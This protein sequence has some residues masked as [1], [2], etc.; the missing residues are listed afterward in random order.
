MRESAAMGFTED[1]LPLIV[2]IFQIIQSIILWPF[3]KSKK[4]L[5]GEVVC[6]TGAGSGIGALMAKKL[7]D[8][9]C[10]IV[11]WDVNVK[12]NEATVEEIRKNGGE[13]YGFKCDV[14]NREEVYEVAKKSAKLAGDVTMLINNAG[15]VGGK[16]FLEADDAMVQKTFEVNSISHFWTTKAFLPKMVENNHGHIVSIASSAGYF[17]VPKLADYCAS[18]AAAAHFADSLSVELYKANSAVKVSWIC[19]YFISTGMFEGAFA[20]RPWL[21]PFLTPETAVENIVYGIQTNADRVCLP[22]ILDLLMAL[23]QMLPRTASLTF[24]SWAGVID[25]MNDFVGRKKSK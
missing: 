24:L 2:V 25:A 11:A 19:P 7:A 1:F 15:I 20:R 5:N 16:S 22:K 10:V 18:K 12:G 21:V 6:I 8:L 13:A 14:T 3:P 9:G 23:A 4:D 17:P